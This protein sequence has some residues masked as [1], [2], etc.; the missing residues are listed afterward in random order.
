MNKEVIK[1]Y[2]VTEFKTSCD[3]TGILGHGGFGCVRLCKHK[4][5]GFVAVKLFNPVKMEDNPKKWMKEVDLIHGNEHTNVLVTHGIVKCSKFFGIVLEFAEC[6]DLYSLI[7]DE[8]I[9]LSWGLRLK[10]MLDT[11]KGLAHLHEKKLIHRDLKLQNILLSKNLEVK[12]GDFGSAKLFKSMTST[13]DTKSNPRITIV[14]AA[15]E[16]LKDFW[17]KPKMDQDMYSFAM[18]MY[19]ITTR[20]HAN[21]GSKRVVNETLYVEGIKHGQRPKEMEEL[22]KHL[23]EENTPLSKLDV[24]LVSNL[25]ETVSLCWCQEPGERL[26]ASQVENE[27][28]GLLQERNL[29][30]VTAE[31]VIISEKVKNPKNLEVFEDDTS[32]LEKFSYPFEKLSVSSEVIGNIPPLEGIDIRSRNASA[33]ILVGGQGTL[34]DA[35]AVN[36]SKK[37][38][39]DLPS[40]NTGRCHHCAVVLQ[41]KLFVMGGISGSK[42]LNSVEYMDLKEKSVWKEVAPMHE[43]RYL[44][45]AET[46]NDNI[47]IFGGKNEK[48]EA[49]KSIE[50]FQHQSNQWTTLEAQLSVERFNFATFLLQDTIYCCGGKSVEILDSVDIFKITDGN[51]NYDVKSSSECKLPEGRYGACSVVHGNN[52]AF[53]LGG[54][55]GKG[56][57]RSVLCF[58]DGVWEKSFTM[59]TKRL[60]FSAQVL[61]SNLY[62][63]G[64]HG[65][66]HKHLLSTTIEF[67]GLDDDKADW[68]FIN[69]TNFGQSD[70]YWAGHSVII[71]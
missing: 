33:L 17:V 37:Q 61:G 39:Q 4:K 10:F 56:F 31:A 22:I 57:I 55:G 42:V 49:L 36:P 1:Q 44:A 34:T 66:H 53:L 63:V 14:Y 52:K 23:K 67:R 27:L 20:Q 11:A 28:A 48:D 2:D 68:N 51:L 12:I 59:G 3:E 13:S 8:D 71:W 64:G 9:Q 50:Q 60:S 21:Y 30:Y 58:S 5:L 45:A 19:E 38:L 24:E 54:L 41:N 46:F 69:L 18:I 25:K 32:T 65:Q 29:E 6:K 35:C 16:V 70:K 43:C 47:Y 7:F 62:A 15:P 40:L 26:T